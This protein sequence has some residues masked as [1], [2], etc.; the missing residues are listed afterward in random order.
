VKSTPVAVVTA[1]LLSA[2]GGGN[3]KTASFATAAEAKQA[4]DRGWIPVN[5]PSGAYELRAA[6]VPDSWQ[7]WGIINFRDD[8]AAELRG[9]LQPE[10]ISLAGMRC[11]VP[12]RI[13]WWPVQLRQDLDVERIS[14]TGAR[15]YRGR[16]AH[17]VW[18][19]NWK[20]G[21]AYYWTTNP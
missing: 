20:Q 10:E 19:I 15:A 13:E 1:L 12:P 3:A 9:L 17:M 6:Y 7:R 14:A 21:R 18:V 11:E 4:I 2:C 8:S 16:T 5:L